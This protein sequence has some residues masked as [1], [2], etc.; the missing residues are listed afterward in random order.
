MKCYAKLTDEVVIRRGFG[1]KIAEGMKADQHPL[2]AAAAV[3]Y[4]VVGDPRRKP[5][6]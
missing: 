3:I 1:P 5:V 6:E 2:E 4:Q